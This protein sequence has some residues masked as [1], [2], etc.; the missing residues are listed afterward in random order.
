M[1]AGETARTIRSPDANTTKVMALVSARTQ[2][3][4]ERGRDM[5]TPGDVTEWKRCI[6]PIAL[7]AVGQGAKGRVE[8]RSFFL[9]AL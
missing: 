1:E 7:F 8:A 3:G 5:F 6:I 4:Y 2:A 9:P